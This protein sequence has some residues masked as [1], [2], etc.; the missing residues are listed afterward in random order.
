VEYE[1]PIV[2]RLATVLLFF[3]LTIL[4]LAPYVSESCKSVDGVDA[5]PSLK[6][7]LLKLFT[8]SRVYL[9]YRPFVSASTRFQKIVQRPDADNFIL[10]STCMLHVISRWYISDFNVVTI[11]F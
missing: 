5:Q 1:S 9:L 10:T 4:E 7:T 6:R 3:N 8:C 11:S 2:C